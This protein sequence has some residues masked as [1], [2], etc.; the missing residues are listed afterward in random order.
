VVGA[1]RVLL[2]EG[3]SLSARETVT[4]LGP[5]GYHLEVLDPDPLCIARFSRWSRKVHRCPRPGTD[6][7]G[8]LETVR[9]VAADRRIDALLPTHEQAW[10]FAASGPLLDGV[11]TA[12]ADLASFHRVQ[13]KVEFARLLDELALPQPEWRLVNSEAD[14]AGLPFPYWLKTAFST[15]G[16]GV[17]LVVDEPSRDAAA[18]EL[19]ELS[20][21]PVMAQ[22]PA[23]GQYGQVQGLFDRGRLVAAHTSVQTG[24]GIGPS[25]AARLS[26][27][28][29]LARD[30]IAKVGEVLS[31]HGGLTL[32]Y[33]H[34][35]GIPQ[36]IECNPRTVEPGNATA[37]GVNLPELQ[38]R[39]TMRGELP[40]EP[41]VGKAG[42]RTH[43]TLALILGAAAYENSRRAVIAEIVRAVSRRGCYRQSAEQLTPVV[44]DPTSAVALA[45]VIA[46]ALSSPQRA[47]RLASGTVTRYSIT[48]DTI[49]RLRAATGQ[50]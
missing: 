36:Y 28:H 47:T 9:A 40:S 13:S 16:R 14:L 1:V 29:P 3:S 35:D 8:Y 20:A 41:A 30:H 32:D 12:V 17:R 42:V 45:F 43:G 23:A 24:T 2:S 49:T 21:G 27:D 4:C 7:L 34:R 50:K 26:V 37:S 31:W 15:A 11:P 6:P 19:L 10:L 22:H 25:A 5:V 48:A 38:V 46:H 39:L 44:R 18:R 33:L